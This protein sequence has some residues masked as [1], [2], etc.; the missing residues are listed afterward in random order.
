MEKVEGKK[1]SLSKGGALYR[2]GIAICV[3]FTG[4]S[5]LM[6]PGIKQAQEEKTH[7]QIDCELSGFCSLGFLQ[8]ILIPGACT[9]A[10]GL[11]FNTEMCNITLPLQGFSYSLVHILLKDGDS[12]INTNPE[13]PEL[14]QQI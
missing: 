3:S 14:I 9:G 1:T 13:I 11:V 8:Q 4:Q 2:E 5:L 7:S 12:S 10:S 6:N